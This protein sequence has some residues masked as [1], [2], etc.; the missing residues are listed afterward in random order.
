MD[1]SFV[2][3][4]VA[5]IKIDPF[6]VN[7]LYVMVLPEYGPVEQ[8]VRV[9]IPTT[10]TA[11]IEKHIQISAESEV[12]YRDVVERSGGTHN[13]W[14]SPPET[15]AGDKVV[16]KVVRKG[17]RESMVYKKLAV[18]GDKLDL[19]VFCMP[20]CKYSPGFSSD[21][22]LI[23]F[24]AGSLAPGVPLSEP[25]DLFSALSVAS[26]GFLLS[27]MEQLFEILRYLHS[28]KICH[29]DLKFENVILSNMWEPQ[30]IDLAGIF[31]PGLDNSHFSATP[32]Y[33]GDFELTRLAGAVAADWFAFTMM[34]FQ[35][36]VSSEAPTRTD[37]VYMS[38]MILEARVSTGKQQVSDFFGFGKY[39]RKC[40][41]FAHRDVSELFLQAMWC[42]CEVHVKFL[43]LALRT[44]NR[45][46][47]SRR[48]LDTALLQAGMNSEHEKRSEMDE[49]LEKVQRQKWG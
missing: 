11:E 2:G 23:V 34:L 48:C 42:P 40:L 19:R 37:P 26:S 30:L 27:V 21:T 16:V 46:V 32:G 31:F 5:K 1:N 24:P 22:E 6:S 38:K 41:A 49:L 12:H 20:I 3:P 14:T 39:L 8:W 18:S 9:K 15:K 7:Y 33:Y 4:T 17:E 36:F 45:D 47:P 43:L 25:A 10:Q 28:K 35:I 44:G 29:R 13:I